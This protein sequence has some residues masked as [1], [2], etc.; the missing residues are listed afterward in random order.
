MK[1]KNGFYRTMVLFQVYSGAIASF[2]VPPLLLG[3]LGGHFCEN[4]D[5]HRGWMAVLIISG[6]A[7]GIY[8]AAHFLARS[9][10]VT[11]MRSPQEKDGLYRIRRENEENKSKHREE[12]THEN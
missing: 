4:Y 6:L 9:A 1:D 7:F 5:M 11:A 12:D 3:L 2:A 8:S 10:S